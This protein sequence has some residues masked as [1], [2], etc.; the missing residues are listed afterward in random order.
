VDGWTVDG[1]GF[2]QNNGSLDPGELP[3][4]GQDVCGS[5]MAERTRPPE[6]AVEA[7]LANRESEAKDEDTNEPDGEKDS[8]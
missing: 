8:E 4:V 7:V 2:E 5:R 6:L 1:G 3:G